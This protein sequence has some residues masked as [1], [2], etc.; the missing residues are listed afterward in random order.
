MVLQNKE[1]YKRQE[2]KT[3]VNLNHDREIHALSPLSFS[4]ANHLYILWPCVRE[5]YAWC[6]DI[7]TADYIIFSA[8]QRR[9]RERDFQ[10]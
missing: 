1:I 8:S 10:P 2:L 5:L 3:P 9:E 6:G 4:F 7:R